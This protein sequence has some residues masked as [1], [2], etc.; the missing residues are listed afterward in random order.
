[1]YAGEDTV[2]G[3]GFG[4]RVLRDTRLPPPGTMRIPEGFTKVKKI[5]FFLYLKIQFCYKMRF[6]I[7]K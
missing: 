4:E 5:L 6:F 3:I 1:M 2:P 7:T